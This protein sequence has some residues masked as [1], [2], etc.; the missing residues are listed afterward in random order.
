MRR[1]GDRLRAFASRW[2]CPETMTRLIDPLI[3]D[4]RHEHERAC[5]GGR[6]WRSRA[7]HLAGGIAF[8]KVLAI[9]A[10][11]DD[12]APR[13]WTA[14]DRRS[15]V[16]TVACS[17]A[18]IVLITALFEIPTLSNVKAWRGRGIS[19]WAPLAL[20][21]QVL[22]TAMAVGAT[23]GIVVAI[24]GRAFSRRVAGGVAFL[25]VV[26]SALSLVNTGWVMPAANQAFRAALAGRDD[27][28]KGPS[29]L[30]FVELSQAIGAVRQEPAQ[31][32]TWSFFHLK[33]LEMEYHERWALSFSPLV[34]ALFA[35]SIAAGGSLKRWMLGIAGC[36][37]FLGYFVLSYAG[38]S[39]VFDGTLPAYVSAWFPN[40]MFAALA[41]FLMIRKSRQ[42]TWFYAA[43]W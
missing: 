21:P 38:R 42:S 35:L 30:T 39:L 22:V 25:A 15:L 28:A 43:P 18:L 6:V 27:V 5:R 31:P 9:C 41:G 8:L 40:A 1:P 37:A 33:S 20:V 10:W 16:R 26:V 13:N 23:L 11:Q 3:A 14:D 17:V 4:L 36:G 34:L 29:E 24:G 12:L 7:I 19:P 2:C 32:P